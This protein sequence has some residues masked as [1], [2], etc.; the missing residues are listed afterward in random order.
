MKIQKSQASDWRSETEIQWCPGC[1]N[2]AILE[3]LSQALV[4][5]GLEPW[6]VCIVSGIGQAGKLPHYLRCN[7]LHGLHG[8]TLAQATGVKLANPELAVIAIGGDGDIYGEGGGHL[9]HA[10][11]RNLD[12]T[13]LVHNNGV[14]GL[15]KGQPSPTSSCGSVTR[16]TPKGTCTPSLNPVAL[17]IG[18]EGT[19]VSRGFAGSK[20][21]LTGLIVRAVRHR[22]FGFVDILQPCVTYNK[23]NTFQWYAERIYDLEASGH[24]PRNRET[25]LV[26]ALEWP[27][28][29]ARIPIGVFYVEQRRTYEEQVPTLASGVLTQAASYAGLL[30]RLLED[31][32]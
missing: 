29:D 13:C 19:F 5:L 9:V 24:D 17:G 28:S 32:K 14:Y 10:F 27:D 15:T 21:H 3:A 18:A 25:A 20:D 12:I 31:F 26:R 11:R 23:V 7:F 1:G 8:R 4:V 22:G 6:Q 30:K 2:Y 16:M